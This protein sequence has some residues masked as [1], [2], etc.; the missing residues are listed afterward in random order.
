MS[1]IIPRRLIDDQVQPTSNTKLSVK[2]TKKP[3]NYLKYFRLNRS[4]FDIDDQDRIDIERANAGLCTPT[5]ASPSPHPATP[6]T[7][8]ETIN[9][10]PNPENPLFSAIGIASGSGASLRYTPVNEDPAPVGQFRT[11]SHSS[12]PVQVDIASGSD[13]TVTPIIQTD[14]TVPPLHNPEDIQMR[15]PSHVPE[16]PRSPL[17]RDIAPSPVIS[18]QPAPV[19]FRLPS[20]P[21]FSS[22]PAHPRISLAEI[23]ALSLEQSFEE[24]DN[25]PSRETTPTPSTYTAPPERLYRLPGFLHP[26][27]HS[28]ASKI[29]ADLLE[30]ALYHDDAAEYYFLKSGDHRTNAEEIRRRVAEFDRILGHQ[31]VV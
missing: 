29:R 2:T 7:D 13:T 27:T 10:E 11:P 31:H 3:T 5:P 26:R 18:S 25:N 15:S 30:E 20:S 12:T 8:Y 9:F 23:E 22:N 19:F 24:P 21:S 14:D 1:R 17:Y 16:S 28:E 6:D 4:A